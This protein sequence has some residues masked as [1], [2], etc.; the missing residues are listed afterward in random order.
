MHLIVR[1]HTHTHTHTLK[2]N[3]NGFV[4]KQMQWSETFELMPTNDRTN[5]IANH[6]TILEFFFLSAAGIKW[7]KLIPSYEIR[8]EKYVTHVKEEIKSR[9]MQAIDGFFLSSFF[10][11]FRNP[12][13]LSTAKQQ[14]NQYKLREQTVHNTAH[15][16]FHFALR[17]F[18]VNSCVLSLHMQWLSWSFITEKN[19]KY[20]FFPLIWCFLW[21]LGI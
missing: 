6:F 20:D 9:E 4:W 5:E 21:I 10:Q 13:I 7:N 8:R 3:H 12:P 15:G 11:I 16:L 19:A 14:T 18:Y 2:H 1:V 17:N